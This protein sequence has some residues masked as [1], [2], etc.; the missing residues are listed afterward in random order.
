MEKAMHIKRILWVLLIIYF[1]SPI[2]SQFWRSKTQKKNPSFYEIQQAFYS[3]VE[4]L[5]ALKIS[6]KDKKRIHKHFKRYEWFLA[7]RVNTKGYINSNLMWKAIQDKK[8]RATRTL[9][10]PAPTWKELGPTSLP[11]E[12]SDFTAGIGRIDCI[13]IDPVH[14]NIMW[15]GAPTGG[16]WKS[17]NGGKHWFS[18]DNDLPT[19]AIS[20]IVIDPR[21]NNVMYLATGDFDSMRSYGQGVLK[22][23]DGGENWHL[24]GLQNDDYIISKILMHPTDS[25][26]LIATT[27]YGIY[28]TTNGGNK[29]KRKQKGYFS[30]IEVEPSN[31]AIW[32]ATES[33]TGI[34]R[35]DDAG[36]SW[37][38]L[39]QVAKKLPASGFNR[40]ELAI[41]QQSPHNIYAVFSDEVSSALLGV[42]C[43]KGDWKQWELMSDYPN[44]LGWKADGTNDQGQGHYDLT[45]AVHPTDP[46]TVFIGGVNFWVS[47]DNGKQWQCLAHWAG[48]NRLPYVHADHHALVFSPQHT[49]YVATDGGIFKSSN[50]GVQWQNISDGLAVNQIFRLGSSYDGNDIVTGSQDN[51]TNIYRAN[52][53]TNIWSGDGMECII[54]PTDSSVIYIENEY[55]KLNRLTGNHYDWMPINCGI[56]AGYPDQGCQGRDGRASWVTPFV[57]D[58]HDNKTLYVLTDKVYKS[59]NQGDNWCPISH[60]LFLHQ[61]IDQYKYPLSLAVAPSDANYIYTAYGNILYRTKDGGKN[62]LEYRWRDAK[63]KPL[64]ITTSYIAV[65]PLKPKEVWVTVFGFIDGEKVYRS[66]NAGNSWKNMSGS[67]ANIPVNCIVIDPDPN[68]ETVY[69]GTDLGVQVFQKGDNNWQYFGIGL[70]NVIINELEITHSSRKMR[71][72]TYG[73]GLWEVS[74]KK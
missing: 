32:Y 2:Y 62:W 27:N 48:D 20:W 7:T 40:V 68:K 12:I 72:A 52:S 29:W 24:S 3:R 50:F 26:T 19:L 23:T 70:P 1:S 30:D 60:V 33:S 44:I 61:G 5:T 37:S 53:W 57:I 14:T 15:A 73:R 47:Q 64:N 67:I 34:F 69:I 41:S 28:K 55:G 51:G 56:R 54:D 13:A 74:V 35:S 9:K 6:P 4:S 45:I 16:L 42:Y 22:S 66:T 46:N 8:K 10:S 71:A 11:Y 25:N 21:D 18:Q 49:L 17:T 39:A 59:G 36:D 58:P 63:G 31:P 65:H 38:P 43:S